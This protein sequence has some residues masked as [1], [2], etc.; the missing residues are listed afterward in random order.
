MRWTKLELEPRT[1]TREL[2]VLRE[3]VRGLDLIKNLQ[4]DDNAA[5]TND[6]PRH[7]AKDAED[8]VMDYLGE[9][10][11][12]WYAYMKSQGRHTLD[13]VPLDIIVTHPAVCLPSC[14]MVE[15]FVSHVR[16]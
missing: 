11:R 2:D 4:S 5:F 3:L 10:A 16:F 14:L 9:V 6:I 15:N 12:E 8:I 1:T 7:L 13:T